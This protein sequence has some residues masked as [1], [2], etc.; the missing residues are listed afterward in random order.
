MKA[1][2]LTLTTVVT[3][4]FLFAQAHAATYN[5]SWTGSGGYTLSGTFS[6]DDSLLGTGPIDESDLDEL[7][8]EVFLNSVSQGV[9]EMSSF[10]G[11]NPLNFNFDTLTGEFLVGG[12]TSG[13]TGQA[14]NFI[15]STVGFASGSNAQLVS[16]NNHALGSESQVLVQ[17]STLS[18]TAIPLPSSFTMLALGVLPLLLRGGVRSRVKS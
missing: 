5:I 10:D 6:F 16:V 13:P 2:V 8:I 4:I 14:W 15:G 12:D 3:W 1:K 11:T 9:A 17:N 7:S 18:A